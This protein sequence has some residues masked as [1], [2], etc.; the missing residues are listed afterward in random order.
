MWFPDS[1]DLFAEQPHL[2]NL[3]PY[4]GALHD[5]G[6]VIPSS[7]AD[8]LFA[9]LLVD[10]PWVHDQALINGERVSTARMVAWF[11]DRPYRYAHS[12]IERRAHGWTGDALLHIKAGIEALIGQ[13]FNA[14]VL[15]LYKE[16]SQGMGWHR[17]QEA[18]PPHDVIAS[19]S[20]GAARKFA[21]KHQD[22]LEV[23]D[24]I[25]GHGQVIVMRG[26]TQRHWLHALLKTRVQV[27][28]RINLT[29]RNFPDDWAIRG[30][31]LGFQGAY[32]P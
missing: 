31:P 27:G 7:E 8:E 18:V 5:Y 16:G 19:V 17:D 29:F 11:A 30:N 25:L 3:L 10:T 15:N 13:R 1:S 2:L 23:R 24:L 26:E 20:F 32:A 4:S 14:C 21:L 22:T 6:R 12:G 9:S 28:P